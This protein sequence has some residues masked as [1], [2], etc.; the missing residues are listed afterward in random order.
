MVQVFLLHV[1]PELRRSY[2]S[3]LL[4]QIEQVGVDVPCTVASPFVL[5]SALLSCCQPF[6][7]WLWTSPELL[8]APH[9]P[10]AHWLGPMLGLCPQSLTV[11]LPDALLCKPLCT[12]HLPLQLLLYVYMINLTM[13]MLLCWVCCAGGTGA[14]SQQRCG[15]DGRA[16]TI[17]TEKQQHKHIGS[18]CGNVQVSSG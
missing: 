12:C 7:R 1:S 11:R 5:W 3:M 13:V 9:E 16:W 6:C 15:H 17:T 2:E 18:V 8:P 14:A 4:S 10:L